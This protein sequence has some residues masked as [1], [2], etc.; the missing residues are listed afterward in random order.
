M[1][2]ERLPPTGQVAQA[3][4]QET[5][6][7]APAAPV[8]QPSDAKSP[9]NELSLAPFVAEVQARNPS[10]RAMAA[11]WRAAAARY[12]QVVSLDDP[13][14]G[15]MIGPAG[16]GP[17][18]GWMVMASQKFPWSYKRTLRGN[19]AAAEAD[20]AGREVADTRL[21]LA[22]AATVAFFDY[23]LIRRQQEVNAATAELLKEFREIA[24]TKYEANQVSQQDVLQADLELADLEGRR[25]ELARE[26]QIAAARINTLLHRAAD[27]RLPPPPKRIELP[28]GT[29]DAAG[30][31]QLAV[32]ER[33]DLAAEADRIRA[34]EASVALACR[35]FYPD[36]EMVAK[37]DAFM[38]EDMRAQVGMNVNVPLR[39]ERRCGALQEAEAKLQQ[40]RAEYQARIDQIQLEVQ[41][42]AARLVEGRRI[43]A[44]YT[45]R[46]LPA[47]E[48]NAESAR[49][50][51][52]SGKLD[53]LR[54]IEAQRQLYREQ[55]KYHQ[56]T[57]D[58]HRRLA[59]LERAV[60]TSLHADGA[61]R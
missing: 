29:F 52:S 7:E 21:Q 4:Y 25:L 55:D 31:Q 2:V 20:A 13:M 54:L 14:F 1:Q 48:A 11:A 58:Y 10:L 57:A 19:I 28:E 53:F 60:G 38:P 56:A 49:A 27:H 39:R 17:E 47:A 12:P 15:F 6:P 45:E 23:Y 36:V 18:G 46:I 32:A 37:Y 30:L 33:P 3:A 9:V 61:V 40:R 24:K 5:L 50:N 51:Y 41:T 44:L 34:E 59:E 22:E 8:E 16:V 35:E 43:V 26:E 42:A